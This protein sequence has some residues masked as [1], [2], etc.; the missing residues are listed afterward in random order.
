MINIL[1][2]ADTEEKN[3]YDYYNPK[4]T[5]GTDLIISC[6]DLHAK[7]LEF[8]ATVVNKPLLY[9][10][11]NHDT[12]YT[13]TPPEG[14]ISIEDRVYEFKGIRIA[15]LGGSYKY[16]STGKPYM[17]SEK[18]MARRIRRLRGRIR[19]HEGIDI[20][21]AHAPCEGYG[22]RE[23]LPHWGFACFNQF[24]MEYKPKLFLYGHVHKEYGEFERELQHES[25][26]KLINCYGSI[27][28]PFDETVNPPHSSSALR[29]IRF[30]NWLDKAGT[31]DKVEF[32]LTGGDDY[33]I[34]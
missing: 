1:A 4:R 22:D 27:M 34:S 12:E 14:C 6:G 28:I 26:T 21:V 33:Y 16:K 9:V 17:Y 11:G 24:M 19:A 25:G 15:G 31:K 8:L 2:V 13:N 10:N 7:Y 30:Y 5:E 32:P 20:L 3:L 18:E 23:D 29:K